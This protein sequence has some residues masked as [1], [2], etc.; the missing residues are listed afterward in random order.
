MDEDKV[1]AYY[2][3]AAIQQK[4]ALEPVFKAFLAFF[5]ARAALK[6]TDRMDF[7][8]EMGAIRQAITEEEIREEY[9]KKGS[10]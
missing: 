5:D 6:G 4:E 7:E 1:R 8:I 2:R 3:A 10:Y 9:E